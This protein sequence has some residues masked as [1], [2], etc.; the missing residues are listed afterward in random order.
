MKKCSL[1][2]SFFLR[3]R[4]L[5]FISACTALSPLTLVAQQY[6]ETDLVS[7][8][9]GQGAQ[10]VDPNLVNP[11]GIARSSTSPWWVSDEARGVSTLYDG[12]GKAQPL[13]VTIPHAAQ[14]PI[15]SPTGVVFNGSSGFDVESGKP[16][17]FIFASFDGTISAW[18]PQANPTVAIEKVKATPGS[19]LT[20]A[21]IAQVK[22][23]RFLYV[24][25]VNEGKIRV[26]DKNFHPVQTARDAFEDEHLPESFVPFNVQNIGGNLYVSFAQQNQAKNFVNFGQGLGTVDVFSPQGV[27][28]QRLESGSWFNAPWGLVLAPTDFGSFSHSVLVGQFGSSEILAFDSVTGRFEGKLRNQDDEVISISG[29]W[30]IAF[31]AGNTNSGGANELFFNAG[32]N[33]GTGGLFGKLVPVASDL[34]QGNDQ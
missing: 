20:G 24:A 25:D 18:N 31:G 10:F 17:I 15:G 19:V 3:R 11:W 22:N 33:Q 9:G 14:A 5:T 28:L 4:T 1:L 23:Q 8:A 7:N 2:I 34:T 16:A 12:N 26:F 13:V 29:L 6:Q 21:A 32:I 27:L 30:G